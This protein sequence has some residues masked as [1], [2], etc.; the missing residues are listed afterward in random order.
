MYIYI[1]YFT[2]R[3]VLWNELWREFCRRNSGKRSGKSSA[4]CGNAFVNARTL[5]PSLLTISSNRLFEPSLLSVSSNRLVKPSRR[6]VICS[7]IRNVI[8]INGTVN[9]KTLQQ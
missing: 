5:Y 2:E 1:Y 6:L 9:N 4:H 7:Y 3:Q 8:Y